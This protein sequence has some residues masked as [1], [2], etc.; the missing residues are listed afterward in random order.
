MKSHKRNGKPRHAEALKP[1]TQDIV[2]LGMGVEERFLRLCKEWF[3][4]KGDE[5]PMPESLGKDLYRWRT[6]RTRHK[7]G[8]FRNTEAE[9][10]SVK[11]MAQWT[12]DM[13]C[14]LRGQPPTRI[15][16]P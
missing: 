6:M 1:S 10:E 9:F 4:V 15:E 3:R 16:W 11:V 12:V 13:N 5:L 14:E 7:G 8:D 2:A